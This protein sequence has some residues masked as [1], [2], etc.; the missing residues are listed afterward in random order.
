MSV[1]AQ[2]GLAGVFEVS[3]T[4]ARPPAL[5][6]YHTRRGA[7][8]ACALCESAEVGAAYFEKK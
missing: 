4:G 5:E 2:A 1:R 7:G 3:P 8:G 6:V